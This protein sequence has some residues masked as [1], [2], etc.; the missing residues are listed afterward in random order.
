MKRTI[1]QN[2]QLHS[3]ISRFKIDKERKQELILEVTDGRASSSADLEF[4]EAKKLIKHLESLNPSIPKDR[5]QAA[6]R[7]DKMRKKILSICH[8]MG[9]DWELPGGAINWKHLNDWLMKYGYLHK[10]L[11]AY[12]YEQL[13]E[14]VTQ[15]EQVLKSFYTKKK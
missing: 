6:M 13:P 4:T 8:E 10:A 1:E 12:T 14:L 3:L 5:G 15:F 2:K 9:G 7:A 11:N